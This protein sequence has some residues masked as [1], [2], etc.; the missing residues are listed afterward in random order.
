MCSALARGGFCLRRRRRPATGITPL[1]LLGREESI[2]K[3]SCGE[4]CVSVTGGAVDA[5]NR[6][7]IIRTFPEVAQSD[8]PYTLAI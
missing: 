1:A 4:V 8:C 5:F 7:L 6:N 3:K 2:R